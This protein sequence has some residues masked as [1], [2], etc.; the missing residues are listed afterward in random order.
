MT[1]MGALSKERGEAAS[2]QTV[3]M[4]DNLVIEIVKKEQKL[5]RELL[6]ALQRERDAII[7]F[8]LEGIIQENNSK[9]QIL[10]ELEYLKGQRE[11]LLDT[12]CDRDKI[13]VDNRWKSITEE[14]DATAHEVKVALQKNM[15]LLSFSADH[16]KASIER[17]MSFIGDSSYGRKSEPGPLLV[18]KVI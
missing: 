6:K 4:N 5:L 15:R 14:M 8:S 18:S 13:L 16:V 10:G 7:S 12:L 11:K 3:A 2:C 17:I 1:S 9:E